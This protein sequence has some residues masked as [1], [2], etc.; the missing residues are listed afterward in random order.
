MEHRKSQVA[1]NVDSMKVTGT[2]KIVLRTGGTSGNATASAFAAT[3][4]NT[5]FLLVGWCSKPERNTIEL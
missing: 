5:T 4:N 3:M 1:I 2:P